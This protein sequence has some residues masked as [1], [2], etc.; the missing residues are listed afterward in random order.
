MALYRY[1]CPVCHGTNLA[2]EASVE[3]TLLQST[4]GNIETEEQGG[5]DWGAG[6]L[7][8]C[9]DCQ[10]SAEVHYF[11]TDSRVVPST[12][13]RLSLFARYVL[14]LLSGTAEWDDGTVDLI[15]AEAIKLDIGEILQNGYFCGVTGS[16]RKAHANLMAVEFGTME[17]GD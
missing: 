13:E 4:D 16:A 14:E 10:H 11:D 8:T 5:H 12:T 15:S 6:S 7:M 2:V 17:A 1:D 3:C 9:L